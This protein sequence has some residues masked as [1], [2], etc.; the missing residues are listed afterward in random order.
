MHTVVIRRTI[1]QKLIHWAIELN[2]DNV[3]AVCKT[4][5]INETKTSVAIQKVM[6][7]KFG[8]G[9]S[10]F[11]TGVRDVRQVDTVPFGCYKKEVFE[12][13]GFFDERLTRNQDIEFNKRIAKAGAKIYLIPNITLTYYPRETY[14]SFFV[15]R[16][17]TGQ[18]IIITSFLTKSFS[19]VSIRHFIPL[20]FL[21]SVLVPLF[22]I[23]TMSNYFLFITFI[24]L[25]SYYSLTT[26]R[27]LCLTVKK[28]SVFHLIA[29]FSILHIS[30][31]CGSLFGLFKV[32]K[33][34]LK[35]K[36]NYDV[37]NG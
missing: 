29:A 10:A 33:I 35:K 7:D 6:S 20:I 22:F 9:N 3:G 30:Y 24:S 5:A 8:V 37:K 32:A 26:W 19:N 31:G 16:F 4:D 13:Y 15:N 36:V 23:T 28:T 27:S 18:W 34:I 11:R 12:K 25:A 2:A 17:N 14:Q 21:L 1:F